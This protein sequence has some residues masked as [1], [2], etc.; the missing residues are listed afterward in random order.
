MFDSGLDVEFAAVAAN[1]NTGQLWT[2]CGR[3]II[4]Y[5]SIPVFIMGPRNTEPRTAL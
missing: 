1:L 3:E 2:P 5:I 4:T